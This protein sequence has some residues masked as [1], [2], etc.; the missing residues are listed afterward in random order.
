M[1]DGGKPN[2]LTTLHLPT[3]PSNAM[4]CDAM[5]YLMISAEQMW[6][7][8]C[9]G[10]S[11]FKASLLFL[12]LTL[13]VNGKI[14]SLKCRRWREE[15]INRTLVVMKLCYNQ[16]TEFDGEILTLNDRNLRCE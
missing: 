9:K 12:S 7:T 13:K 4:R 5:P 10:C 14:F 15:C 16:F 2:P 8:I 3:L 1:G 11:H 6:M